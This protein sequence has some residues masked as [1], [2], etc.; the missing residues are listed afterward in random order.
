M[1]GVKPGRSE[2]KKRLK[3]D[4]VTKV[5]IAKKKGKNFVAFKIGDFGCMKKA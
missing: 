1:Q 4:A 2:Q 5:I 3:N